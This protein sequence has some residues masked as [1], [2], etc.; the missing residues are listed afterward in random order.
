VSAEGEAGISRGGVCHFPEG[1]WNSI[2]D[3][4]KAEPNVHF[5]AALVRERRDDAPLD[6]TPA[7][8][9]LCLNDMERS[10]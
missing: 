8:S 3:K 10:K 4:T 2:G 7:E 6:I 9:V 5:A 1:G